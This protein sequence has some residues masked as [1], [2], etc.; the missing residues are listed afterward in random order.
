MTR[1]GLTA[2]LDTTPEVAVA[3]VADDVAAALAEVEATAP[4]VVLLAPDNEVEGWLEDL[5]RLTDGAGLPPI[6]LLV[7]APEV[8]PEALR[9]G[10]T[11]LLLRDA[12]PE[13]IVAALRAAALGLTVLDRRAAELVTTGPAP[14]PAPGAGEPLT[15]REREI[16]QLIAHGLP[17]KSIAAELGISEHTVKFHVGSILGKLGAA[18][19]AEA[20]AR[21]ARA[22][23]IVL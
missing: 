1:A 2:L 20:L 6:L 19:R 21:A 17:N 10:I 23:L 4:D 12:E 13:E 8:A 14:R 5:T 11:G 3:G 7:D 16:L 18:S 9:S 15:P 22:G